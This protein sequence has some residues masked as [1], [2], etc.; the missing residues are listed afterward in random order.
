MLWDQTSEF[1][2]SHPFK[3]E[4]HVQKEQSP[5]VLDFRT[6]AVVLADF[7]LTSWALLGQL[8]SRRRYQLTVHSYML[9]CSTWGW[10][11]LTHSGLAL[12]QVKSEEQL[13]ETCPMKAGYSYSS[14]CC[15]QDEQSQS[16]T[17]RP[18]LSM[19]VIYAMMFLATLD[20]LR[21]RTR[22]K[23]NGSLFWLIWQAN[24]LRLGK[25]DL[26]LPRG[27]Q[28]LSINMSFCIESFANWNETIPVILK[29]KKKGS[30]EKE[31]YTYTSF[32][33][34]QTKPYLH[35]QEW[36]MYNLYNLSHKKCHDVYLW[37]EFCSFE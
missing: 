14:G 8:S 37:Y 7:F 20:I 35:L 3:D 2:L 4:N 22:G 27:N 28:L 19:A 18:L 29:I 25:A 13:W 15:F 6:S 17:A 1:R 26:L 12:A 24:I 33:L 5:Q 32:V 36:K 11:L 30:I 34:I 31:L 21:Q 23:P 9:Q 10:P 16:H